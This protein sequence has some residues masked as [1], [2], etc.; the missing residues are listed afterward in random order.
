MSAAELVADTRVALGGYPARAVLAPITMTIRPLELQ[1]ML[2]RVG[3]SLCITV[4][5]WEGFGHAA[6]LQAIAPALPELRHRVVIGETTNGNVEFRSV[7]EQTPWEE[8]HPVALDDA[9]EDRIALP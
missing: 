7:F 6:A 3:A 5:Q 1:R 2:N 8:R 4:D 9:V